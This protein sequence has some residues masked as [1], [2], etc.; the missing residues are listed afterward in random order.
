MADWFFDNSATGTGSGDSPANATTSVYSFF[1]GIGSSSAWA[2]GD[3]LWMRRSSVQTL[4]V[5]SNNFMMG[6]AGWSPSSFQ[7][8]N[9]IIG[10]PK[11]GEPFYE[12]RP[13]AGISA[14]WDSDVNT[15]YPGI[16]MAMIFDVQSHTV[17]VKDGMGL[18][19]IGWH[20]VVGAVS[21][22][23]ARVSSSYAVPKLN[24]H[25]INARFSN[26]QAYGWR[27]LT[28][29]T[30]CD[31]FF[32]GN[33]LVSNMG[34]LTLTNS[35]V[36]QAL[37]G[38]GT[39]MSLNELVI[40]ASSLNGLCDGVIGPDYEIYTRYIGSIRGSARPRDIR[41]LSNGYDSIRPVIIDDY[42]GE[43]PRVLQGPR[44]GKIQLQPHPLTTVNSQRA[45]AALATQS[46]NAGN[47]INNIGRHFR[48][49]IAD[50]RIF[51]SYTDAATLTV[52]WPVWMVGSSML[53][54]TSTGWP[55]EIHLRAA[56][57]GY[58]ATSFQA[59]SGFT[60][61]GNSIT[62]AGSAWVINGWMF[63]TAV[64]SGWLDLRVPTY[65]AANG[66]LIIFGI[67]E[68]IQ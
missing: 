12:S 2:H 11:Y 3:R 6:K 64:G 57:G 15:L 30:S 29:T 24:M 66:D 34:R 31:V 58:C 43:G 62:A 36:L 67:P 54:P 48:S 16:D 42:Y 60:W 33:F 50:A 14:G 26:L 52:R 22:F 19:N 23:R 39:F 27:D 45:L 68:I 37:V 10:W 32:S 8:T 28:I 61:A 4:G 49:A 18:A 9:W 1:W 56:G 41:S 59:S 7:P 13:A 47:P 55:L 51:I 38:G 25:L 63:P 53:D 17:G 46:I 44:P 35:C 65:Y 40:D 21:A 20:N 5:D